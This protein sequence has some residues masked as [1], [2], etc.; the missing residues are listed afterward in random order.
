MFKDIAEG[1]EILTDPRKRNQYD[2]GADLEDINQGGHGSGGFSGHDP[3]EI[4]QMFFGGGGGGFGG[5]HS[6]FTFRTGGGGG[7]HHF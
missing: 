5:G 7:H 6:G 1:Y 3:S 2:Q 4:F